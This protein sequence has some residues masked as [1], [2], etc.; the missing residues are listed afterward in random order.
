MKKIV[1]LTESELM[2]LIGR[3]VKEQEEMED[4]ENA[5]DEH[6]ITLDHI[7]NHFNRNTTEEELDFMIDEIEYEVGSA[8]KEELLSDEEL[9][10]LVDYAEFLID[11]LV[12]EFRLNQDLNSDLQEGTKAKKPKAVKSRRSGIKTQKTIDQNNKVLRKLMVEDDQTIEMSQ[13]SIEEFK[14]EL[15]DV[16]E[17]LSDEEIQE[18]QP[19]CPISSEVPEHKDIVSK[20]QEEL[21]TM[22]I[23]E[24]KNKIKE[25]KAQQKNNPIQEQPTAIG[26][27]AG[28]LNRAG[29]GFAKGV[30]GLLILLCIIELFKKIFGGRERV[31]T[32]KECRQRNRLVR[33]YGL[34]GATM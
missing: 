7:A 10:E 1:R 26:I 21:K 6:M 8:M 28:T 32:S 25:L 11:E 33:R 19:D 2:N 5:F 14:Q 22:S 27:D 24:I 30:V 20:F 9:D 34:R 17:T 13:Q 31:R 29:I 15:Q 23:P 18:L 12:S 4:D 16:G 3:I